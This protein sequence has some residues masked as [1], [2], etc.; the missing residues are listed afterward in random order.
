MSIYLKLYSDPIGYF[1]Y[2][3]VSVYLRIGSINTHMFMAVIK[4]VSG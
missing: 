4:F 3:N 2:C 1:I